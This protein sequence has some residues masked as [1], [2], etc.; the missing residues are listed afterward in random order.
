MTSE[1]ISLDKFGEFIEQLPKSIVRVKGFLTFE[2]RPGQVG[3]WHIVGNRATL[4]MRVLDEGHSVI[5]SQIVFIGEHDGV[6][7]DLLETTLNACIVE[8]LLR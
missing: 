5:Q 7:V 4:K 1:P 6:D 2:E 8:K 3:E